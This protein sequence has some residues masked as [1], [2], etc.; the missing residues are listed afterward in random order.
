MNRLSA[1]LITLFFA[2]SFL[3]IV[4]SRFFVGKTVRPVKEAM[5]SQRQFVSDA[6]HEL[7]TPLTVIINNVGNLQKS[8]E[9]LSAVRNKDR[10][11]PGEEKEAVELS[12]VQNMENNIRGIAEMS[13]RMKRLTESL[14]DLSRLENLQDRKNQLEKLSLSHITE[15]ECLYFEALFYDQGKNLEYKIEEG[16]FTLGNENKLKELLSILLENALKYSLLETATCLRLKKKKNALF[17]TLSNA[18][19]KDLSK[20][21]RQNLFKRFYRLDEAHSGGEG[22]GLGLAIAREIVLMH[23]G[24]IRVESGKNQISFLIRLNVF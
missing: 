4:L 24:E 22:Y 18:I 2:L 1:V 9:K 17:L 14:L 8:A 12:L 20:E 3:I 19:E 6:S 21:E 13:S 7:K 23:K 5:L 10:S 11:L 15:Q 16:L